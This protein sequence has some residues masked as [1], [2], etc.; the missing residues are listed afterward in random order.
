[1]AFDFKKDTKFDTVWL[2]AIPD[3]TGFGA[4]Y[5]QPDE[6]EWTLQLRLRWVKDGVP[7]EG[8]ITHQGTLEDMR[9]VI[10]TIRATAV[11]FGRNDVRRIEINGDLAAYRRIMTEQ[12]GIEEIDIP[13]LK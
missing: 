9:E 2:A 10:D 11:H 5:K 7:D 4:L 1:M 12:P 13:H 8:V 6:K 3:R